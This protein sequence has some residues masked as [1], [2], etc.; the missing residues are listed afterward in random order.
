MSRAT[1]LEVRARDHASPDAKAAQ[2]SYE[3]LMSTSVSRTRGSTHH[4]HKTPVVYR[5]GVFIRAH[6]GMQL[7]IKDCI[8][9]SMQ[10]VIKF[11]C[12]STI[13]QVGGMRWAQIR[14]V[15]DISISDD[16]PLSHDNLSYAGPVVSQT[17]GRRITSAYSSNPSFQTR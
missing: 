11:Q 2:A 8:N 6:R 13:Q 7:N 17:S 15:D 14:S 3:Y 4:D 16:F 12:G 1:I 10:F 5:N 9:S